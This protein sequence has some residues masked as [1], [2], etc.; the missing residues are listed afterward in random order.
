M[1]EEVVET[2]DVGG[3]EPLSDTGS[4][5]G[6]R[7]EYRVVQPITTKDGRNVFVNVGGMWKNVSKNGTEFYTLKIGKLRLLVFKNDNNRP[8]L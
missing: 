3:E 6:N 8:Q 2:L 7:P 1:V 5:K 4:S